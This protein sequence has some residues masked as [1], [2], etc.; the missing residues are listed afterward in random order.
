VFGIE[1]FSLPTRVQQV[2]SWY[3]RCDRWWHNDTFG[4][5]YCCL[6]SVL[7][8]ITIEELHDIMYCY[9]FGFRI[10][11]LKL[12]ALCKVFLDYKINLSLLLRWR[13]LQIK[14]WESC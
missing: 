1:K 3:P 12:L 4:R 10:H 2:A 7:N 14:E 8:Y 5:E 11:K 9:S 13:T 6:Q